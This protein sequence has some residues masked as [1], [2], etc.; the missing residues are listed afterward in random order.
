MDFGNP[1]PDRAL[2][3]LGGIKKKNPF[4]SLAIA[5][6]NNISIFPRREESR[7]QIKMRCRNS[8]LW[9]GNV[10]IKPPSFSVS[11]FIQPTDA[12]VIL[13]KCPYAQ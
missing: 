2:G 12:R 6:C 13:K 4:C 5:E 3:H 9:F 7:T 8:D 11:L 1:L 10:L